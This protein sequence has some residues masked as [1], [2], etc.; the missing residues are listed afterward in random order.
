MIQSNVIHCYRRGAL[1]AMA[2]QALEQ[3]DVSLLY[4]EPRAIPI[5]EIIVKLFH[6]TL[7]YYDLSEDG[8]V[9]G[10]MVFSAGNV[11]IYL[12]E[13]HCYTQ[14]PVSAGTMLIDNLDPILGLDLV[15]K[16]GY[17][18]RS[19]KEHMLLEMILNACY[20][21]SIYECNNILRANGCQLL[22]NEK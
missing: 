21:L 8:N 11:T 5:E 16:A 15:N 19:T 10:K 3:Y 9:L 13:E 22:T 17:N 18:F 4:G 7:E 1:E 2:R 12:R 6:L 20:K 14:I